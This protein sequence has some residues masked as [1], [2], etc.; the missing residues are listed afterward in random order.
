MSLQD[1]DIRQEYRTLIDNIP[2]EFY[3]P[4]LSKANS[5]KRAVGY[6]SST[7]LIEISKGITQL[8]KNNGKIQLVASPNLSQEDIEAIKQGYEKRDIIEKSLIKELESHNEPFEQERLNLLANLIEIGTLDIKIALTETKN[9]IGMYHEKIGIIG[10][11]FG[12]KIAFSGSMNETY[13]GMTVNYESIDVFCSWKD[14]EDRAINKDKAFDLIWDNEDKGVTVLEFKNLNQEIIKKYKQSQPNY[15]IDQLE[16]EN[17]PIEDND[18]N[19]SDIVIERDFSMFKKPDD[20]KFHDYQ[21]K[22][23]QI[24]SENEYQGIYDM[25]TGTGKT[26]TA[27][28]SLEMLCNYLSCKVAIFIVCP[29]QHLVEQWV[30]DIKKF[31]VN[32]L[33]CYSQY[34][35]KQKYKNL[36]FGF[37]NNTIDN[38]CVITTNA[39]FTTNQIQEGIDKLKGN[40]CLVVDEAHNFGAK[41]QIKCMKSVFNYRLALSATLER[42]RDEEGTEKL[43]NYFGKIC[44]KYTLERAIN[45][46]KLTPYKY[47]PI[48]IYLDDDELFEYNELS[49]KISKA[50]GRKQCDDLP[51]SVELLLIK[52]ARIIAGAKNKLSALY[53]IIKDK[54]TNENNML[55]Y[56]GATTVSNYSYEENKINDEEKRQIDIVI[57]MLGNDLD[58]K[59]TRFTSTENSKER[60]LIKKNF[61]K[62]D[63]L[64][65]LVA[66]KCLDEGVN[67]PGI[68]TAFILASST[69]P[70]EYIQ[71]RGRVLRKSKGKAYAEIYDFVTLPQDIENIAHEFEKSELSLVMKEFER[72]KEFARLSLN[73]S[74][75]TKLEDK[76]TEFYKLN[77][78]GDFDYELY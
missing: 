39:T 38:F 15:N 3:L 10:D 59:V 6:F 75:F 33:I 46:G 63:M 70:K 36:I 74:E 77:Y 9:G 61:E 56:C 32:P 44:I 47:Y 62:G 58:M 69:N 71:R 11:E 7:A 52:R 43:K 21:L 64:Q 13:T 25:A 8:V 27:L 16:Y 23:M 29:Y 54:Y 67:I 1:L 42:H 31:N 17:P 53:D 49:N 45:E 14:V 66:I 73:S 30:E 51:Q 57:N 76:I 12:N 20:I 68:K 60:E 2:R 48:P 34:D 4:A 22:A 41:N 28:G 40:V 18:V 19:E 5:Y 78:V 65:A 26:Y 72:M 37:N 24:W 35:Y 55:I 50:M